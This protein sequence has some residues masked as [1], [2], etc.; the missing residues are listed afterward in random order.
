M[1]KPINYRGILEEIRA[2]M[3]N[4]LITIEEAKIEAKPFIDAM[5]NKG[6]DIAKKYGKSFKPLTFGYIFR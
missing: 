1:E 3:Q 6:K 2:R 5:N 4:G